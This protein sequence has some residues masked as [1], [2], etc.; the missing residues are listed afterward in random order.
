LSF[1]KKICFSLLLLPETLVIPVGN[2][3]LA[4]AVA[5]RLSFPKGIR[6][7]PLLLIPL[8]PRT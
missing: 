6:F 8:E 7:S 4:F 5:K 2:L 1:P 3:L